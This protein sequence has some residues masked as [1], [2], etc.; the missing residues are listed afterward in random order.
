VKPRRPPETNRPINPFGA[1][2]HHVSYV[3]D[4]LER[5]IHDTVATLGAGP[6]FILRDVPLAP[7]SGGEPAVFEHSTSFGQ[8]GS[9]PMELMQIDRCDPERV[10][11]AMAGAVPALHHIGLAVSSLD[12]TA[13]LLNQRRLPEFLRAS[14]GEIAFTMHDARRLYGHHIEVHADSDGFRAF[15][16]QVLEASIGWDGRDPIRT[17]DL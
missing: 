15:F 17:P 2:I 1:P 16:R 10:Q 14:I 6:F 12:S 13:E 4:D 5:A 3:V 11:E 9:L 7:T 8:W